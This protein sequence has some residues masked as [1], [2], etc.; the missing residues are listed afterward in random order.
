MAKLIKY[1]AIGFLSLSAL[2]LTSCKQN[3]PEDTKE[4]AQEINDKNM[5]GR[6]AEKNAQFAVD[7]YSEGLLEIELSK[8]AKE[9]STDINVKALAEKMIEAHALVNEEL[10]RIA[11]QKNIALAQGLSEEQQEQYSKLTSKVG[12]D[13]NE[14]YAEKLVSDHKDAVSLYEKASEKEEDLDFKNFFTKTLPEIKHH[15]VSAEELE[16][17]VK[18]KKS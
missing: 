15:L 14:A 4:A 9:K 8:Y 13:L 12:S 5:D 2:I 18:S 16:T 7:A 1:T 6:T 11:D 17:K 10:K 3:A